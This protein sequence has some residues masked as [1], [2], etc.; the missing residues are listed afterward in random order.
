M[1]PV[2]EGERHVRAHEGLAIATSG[3]RDGNDNRASRAIGIQ[4]AQADAPERFDD[5][6]G[7]LRACLVT[8][9]AAARYDTEH[10]HAELIHLRASG[11]GAAQMLGQEGASTTQHQAKQQANCKLLGQADSHGLE[12]EGGVVDDLDLS[13][14]DR[15][16]N[17]CLLVLDAKLIGDLSRIVDPLHQPRILGFGCRQLLQASRQAHS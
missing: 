7:V 6:V 11:D 3:A 10:G 5:G 4:Q 8:I 9:P 15:F 1:A 13:N 2:P 14:R 12:R 17:P 16:R